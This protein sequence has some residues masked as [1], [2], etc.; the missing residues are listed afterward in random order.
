MAE[1]EFRLEIDSTRRP[2]CWF[3]WWESEFELSRSI[4]YIQSHAGNEAMGDKKSKSKRFNSGC[5]GKGSLNRT[6]CQRQLY[7]IFRLLTVARLQCM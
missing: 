7:D 6:T 1:E 3:R 2:I 4:G 5:D